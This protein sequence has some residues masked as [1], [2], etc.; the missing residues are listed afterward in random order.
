MYVRG[1]KL[2][3]FILLSVV[4]AFASCTA[5]EKRIIFEISD[6]NGTWVPDLF[7][8]EMLA[9]SEKERRERAESMPERE[10]SWGY[11]IFLRIAFLIDITAPEPFLGS[12]GDGRYIITEITQIGENVVK[13]IGHPPLVPGLTD[14]TPDIF[15]FIFH[16]IDKD[17][18]WMQSVVF[19]EG[20]LHGED[21]PWHRLS[22]PDVVNTWLRE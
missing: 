11:G 2:F 6:L 7:S 8:Q 9:L 17:T 16:F 15:E 13:V 4:F 5:E 12:F 18:I 1:N 10:F 19:G 14:D 20:I 3:C 21:A 22:G